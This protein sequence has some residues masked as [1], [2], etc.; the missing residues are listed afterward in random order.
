VNNGT[1]N[2][3]A[4]GGSVM[5]SPEITR[6]ALRT[7]LDTYRPRI[8]G[9][10]GFSDGF[11]V[12]RNWWDPHVIGIDTGATLLSIENH[13]SGLIHRLFMRHPTTKRAMDR[14]GFRPNPDPLP[15]VRAGQLMQ[16]AHDRD[17]KVTFDLP[18]RPPASWRGAPL[19]LYG[20]IVERPLT[21]TLNDQPL[22]KAVPEAGPGSALAFRLPGGALQWGRSNTLTLRAE[23]GA[24]MPYGPIEIGP[25]AALE[26]KP[27]AIRAVGE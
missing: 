8:W 1:I 17:M 11:N 12:S 14:I 16:V 26:W 15:S 2:P 13:R 5:F 23:G 19:L 22:G 20:G 18:A 25:R 3:H 7:M 6:T 27:L 9:R 24:P 4:A 10:Y 21:V